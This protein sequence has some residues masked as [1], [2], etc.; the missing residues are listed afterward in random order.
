ML[1]PEN[2]AFIL[3]DVQEKLARVMHEKEALF[4]NLQ[5]IVKGMQVLNIPILWV[6][7]NPEGLGNTIPELSGLLTDIEPVS[8][9]SFSCCGNED[10]IQKLKTLDRSQI[11]ISGIEAHVCVYQT[12]VNLTDTDYEVEVVADAISS[13]TPANKEIAIKKMR[14]YGVRITSVEMALFELLG[15]AEGDTFKQLLKI[16][17]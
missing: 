7:Q 10:F 12:A 14:D 15:R 2:T 6:E 16:V 4:E 8:K 17:K 3:I 5:K 11:L 1:K 13:R 9:L